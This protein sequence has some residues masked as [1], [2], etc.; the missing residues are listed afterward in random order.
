MLMWHWRAP[1]SD[2]VVGPTGLQS[3]VMV[4]EVEYAAG[5]TRS[6]RCTLSIKGFNI[7]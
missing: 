1:G 2:A 7:G 5:H 4:T 6:H 3:R